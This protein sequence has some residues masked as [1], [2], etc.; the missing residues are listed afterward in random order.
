MDPPAC[1]VGEPRQSYWGERGFPLILQN[2]HRYTMYVAVL[3]LIFLWWDALHA[4]WWP[5]DRTGQLLAD[6]GRFGIGLGTIIMVVNCVFLSFYTFGCHSFR[7]LVG[8]R[9]N[10]FSCVA[11]SGGQDSSLR[12]GYKTWRFSTLLNEHHMLWAWLSLFSVGLTD[13]YI[14][15]CAAG[16]ITDIRIL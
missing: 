7:H 15:Q 14:R 5:T 6:G 9:L 13:F 1:A 2:V 10:C 16:V 12:L 4:F 3:F 8:G 11:Q